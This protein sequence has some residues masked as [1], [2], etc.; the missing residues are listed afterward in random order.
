M[1]LIGTQ[2]RTLHR[3]PG[4]H[5]AEP[6]AQQHR[7]ACEKQVLVEDFTVEQTERLVYANLSALLLNH[8][9]DGGVDHQRADNQEDRREGHAE[10]RQL[11]G[12]GGSINKARIGVVVKHNPAAV[13][14]CIQLLFRFVQPLLRGFQFSLLF[15]QLLP[16]LVELLQPGF[17]GSE[18]FHAVFIGEQPVQVL[19]AH[20]VVLTSGLFISSEAVL[21]LLQLLPVFCLTRTVASFF[22]QPLNSFI[23]SH[24]SQF[25]IRNFVGPTG[26]INTKLSQK[27][28][29]LLDVFRGGQHAA[30]VSYCLIEGLD[31][32][33][34]EIEPVLCL[35]Q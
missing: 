13:A 19:L 2:N 26:S 35:V 7:T 29:E 30:S 32:V 8:A 4:Q 22:F 1:R 14:D 20:E 10:R 17:G 33:Q 21:V 24:I 34:P 28:L 27:F 9:R 6:D 25:I 3:Q 5:H 31:C 18:L 12:V 23:G 15:F 11:F 16:G